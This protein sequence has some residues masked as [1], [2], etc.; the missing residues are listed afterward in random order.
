MSARRRL[1]NFAWSA[2]IR[3]AHAG[4]AR[5]GSARVVSVLALCALAGCYGSVVIG[6]DNSDDFDAPPAVSL[7]ASPESVT[8]DGTLTLSAA[9]SDDRGIAN[10]AFYRLD[11]F[12]NTIVLG[13]DTAA[14]YQWQIA[15]TRNGNGQWSYFARAT[16]TAGQTADSSAVSV[17]VA[18]P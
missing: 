6:F 5:V 10:V 8:Q 13:T 12:G 4:R 7:V 15:F 16:D 9:A 14:P 11:A 1:P 17:S 3:F 2:C 18:I